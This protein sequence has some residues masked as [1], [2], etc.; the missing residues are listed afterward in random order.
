MPSLINC[1]ELVFTCDD[2]D[3]LLNE[4]EWI[5]DHQMSKFVKLFFELNILELKEIGDTST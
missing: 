5:D 3:T 2:Y 1:G 4:L